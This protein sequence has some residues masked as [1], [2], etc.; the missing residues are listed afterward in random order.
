MGNPNLY[1]FDENKSKFKFM[2]LI[3]GQDMETNIDL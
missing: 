2:W 1:K 3:T